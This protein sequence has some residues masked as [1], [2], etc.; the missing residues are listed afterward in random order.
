MKVGIVGSRGFGDLAQVARYVRGLQPGTVV[1]SGGALG[2]DSVAEKEA[3][4]LGM[5]TEI[6]RVDAEGAASRGEFARR[7]NA[8]NQLIVDA[9]D[10]LVAFWD[11]ESRGT[12]DSIARA[13]RAGKEVTVVMWT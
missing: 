3:G 6:Y 12:A 1:V 9:S 4:R 13:R 10:R 5:A 2:V 8:R 11:G 7:A